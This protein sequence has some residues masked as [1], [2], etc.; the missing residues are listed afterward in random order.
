MCKCGDLCSHYSDIDNID[1]KSIQSENYS[2]AFSLASV[3]LLFYF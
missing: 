1:I 2:Y 3:K